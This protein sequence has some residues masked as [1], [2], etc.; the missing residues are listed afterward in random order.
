MTTRIPKSAQGGA[1]KPHNENIPRK[2]TAG[3]N[4][5]GPSSRYGQEAE[6]RDQKQHAISNEELQKSL[7]ETKQ[8]VVQLEQENRDLQGEKEDIQ[9][10]LKDC[11]V[12]LVAG[13][14]DPVLGE[15]I[16]NESKENED[17]QR[18][19]VNL[20]KDLLGELK[21]FCDMTT[22]Q[23]SRLDDIQRM[24]KNLTEARQDLM[25]ERRN[26]TLEVEEMEKA[27]EEA[28]ELLLE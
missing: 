12:L 23:R 25:Q 20:S 7:I 11:H 5:K 14:I 16:G 22:E 2:H 28:E 19:V 1:F 18:E 6:S 9:K 15:R 27:L 13:N 10:R 4:H 17:Q 3:K 21:T 26:F 8:R 24:T